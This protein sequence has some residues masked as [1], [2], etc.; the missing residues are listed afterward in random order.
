MKRLW[1]FLAF[2]SCGLLFWFVI[3]RFSNSAG[4]SR[5]INVT[6]SQSHDS[7]AHPEVRPD[8]PDPG[9]FLDVLYSTPITFYGRVIDQHGSPVGGA[10][11]RYQAHDTPTRS[12]REQTL[13]ST[14][15]GAFVISGVQGISLHVQ[16]EKGGYRPFRQE[17][18]QNDSAG[19]FGFGVNLGG[20]RH[21]PDASRPVTFVLQKIGELEPLLVIPSRRILIPKDGTPRLISLHPDKSQTHSIEVSCRTD[22]DASALNQ[23]YSWKFEILAVNGEIQTRQGSFAFRA[24]TTG[25]QRKDAVEMK[26][27]MSRDVWR[28]VAEKSYFVRYADGVHARLDIEMFTGSQQKIVLKSWLNPKPGSQN[29][30]DP[31]H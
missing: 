17:S 18:D 27:S 20:G 11:V 30:E 25:Y 7:A 22:N 10:T 3:G 28:R 8:P 2:V 26:A 16:V 9:K 21:V 14:V 19:S 15:D 4:D 5:S 1:I 31:P 13:T 12:G 23:P 29:L 24:P 6:A